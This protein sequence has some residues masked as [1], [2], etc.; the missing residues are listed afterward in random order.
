ME[1]EV[2][3]LDAMLSTGNKDSEIARVNAGS[4][5]ELSEEAGALVEQGLALYEET[6]KRA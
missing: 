2:S 5:T 1:E 3:R 6:G 4:G